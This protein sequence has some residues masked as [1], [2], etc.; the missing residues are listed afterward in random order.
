MQT[1]L[2]RQKGG[3]GVMVPGVPCVDRGK[4]GRERDIARSCQN[5]VFWEE[6]LGKHSDLYVH[7]EY[8]D[9][10]LFPKSQPGKLM[11]ETFS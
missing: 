1:V 2:C 11:L 8:K 4:C 7:L 9:V 3:A 6:S 5:T 10:D